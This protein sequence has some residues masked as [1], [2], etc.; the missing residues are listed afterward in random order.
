MAKACSALAWNKMGILTQNRALKIELR[1]ASARRACEEGRNFWLDHRVLSCAIF[2]RKR[3]VLF[4]FELLTDLYTFMAAPTK[5]LLRNLSSDGSDFNEN[6]K[7]AIGLYYQK[8]QLC[9]CITLF[10]TL[11]CVNAPLRRENDVKMPYSTFFRGRERK[12][13]TFFSFPELRYSFLEFY[14]RKNCQHFKL[15]NWHKWNN[16]DKVWSSA[17]SL[18]K[19]RF[20]SRR[21][22]CCLSSLLYGQAGYLTN[23]GSQ[24]HVNRPLRIQLNL[25]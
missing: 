22:R 25:P 15:T 24:P 5:M 18:F 16:R 10:Y 17:T 19:W 6:G 23:Q 7:K 9:T 11:R 21:R 3:R 13:A 20:R 14:S 4:N 2:S 1:R 12:T 8:Q